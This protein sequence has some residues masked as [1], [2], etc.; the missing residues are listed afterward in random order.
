[1]KNLSNLFTLNPHDLIKG[2]ITFVF[3]GVITVVYG[4]VSTP[5]FDVFAADWNS[6]LHLA[7]TAAVASFIAYIAKNFL[8][9][10]QGKVLGSIG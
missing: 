7:L 4:V 6:I 9:D 3:S 10:D 5:G 1:M 2:A 8:S